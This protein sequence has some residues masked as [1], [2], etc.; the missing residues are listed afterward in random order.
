M[1]DKIKTR[2]KIVRAAF[3][4]FSEQ[5]FHGARMQSIAENFEI[6]RFI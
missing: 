4:E 6:N 2:N 3:N 5:G 1:G